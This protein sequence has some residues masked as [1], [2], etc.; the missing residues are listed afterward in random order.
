[1]ADDRFDFRAIALMNTDLQQLGTPKMA[2]RDVHDALGRHYGQPTSEE[3]VLIREARS[4][5]G[6]AGNNNQCDLIAIHT[7]ASRGLRV[8]GHE[9]KVSRSDWQTE[10]RKPEKADAFW[11]FCH[12]W[13]LVVPEPYR[14]IVH[15]GELPPNWGLLEVGNKVRQ[16]TTS[17]MEVPQPVPWS[18]CVG[19]LAQMDRREKRDISRE[20]NAAREEGRQL[21]E[22]SALLKSRDGV[23]EAKEIK[24]TAA[25][26]AKATGIDL[27]ERGSWQREEIKRLAALAE[28]YGGVRS[29][30]MQLSAARSNV[31]HVTEAIERLSGDLN[32]LAGVKP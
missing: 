12:Q 2:S 8:V 22:R 19:W 30:M 25:E 23:E 3:W 31:L 6:F 5:A 9:I 14:A 27:G 17:A 7:W 1:M 10:L 11:R 15:D 18:W 29:L 21:G 32:G 16:I 13:F 28:R 24:L 20:L 26:F 4:G